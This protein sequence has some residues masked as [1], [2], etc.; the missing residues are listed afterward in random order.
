MKQRMKYFKNSTIL[1]LI[2]LNGCIAPNP[3]TELRKPS[4]ELREIQFITRT[5]KGE[6]LGGVKIIFTGSTV[7]EEVTTDDHGYGTAKIVTNGNVQ[8]NLTKVG[9]ITQNFMI[10]LSQN[11][12]TVRII[13]F[14][15][16]GIP[17]VVATNPDP[18]AGLYI[19]TDNERIIGNFKI[20][21]LDCN[22]F[23]DSVECNISVS[24]ITTI[25]RTFFIASKQKSG[26]RN[27]AYD[28][29]GVTT[30]IDD[31]GSSYIADTISFANKYGDD[32]GQSFFKAYSNTHP[33]LKIIFTGV[34]ISNTI[35]RLDLVIGE[36]KNSENV[37]QT[38]NIK[39]SV[40][41]K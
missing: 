24:N 9:Y 17:T 38:G 13:T 11:P 33:T 29:A 16:S 23:Q 4:T 8:V 28:K 7:P 35:K 31:N 10:N 3:P 27:I 20:K 25:D 34:E 40:Q 19:P 22:V 2:L 12:N 37:L 14:E 30:I 15:Q 6:S 21:L 39:F 41:P 26:I 5:K 32:T 36:Y 1:S 18:H